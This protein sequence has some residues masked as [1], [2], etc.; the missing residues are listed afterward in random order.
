MIKSEWYEVHVTCAVC[1][2][3]YITG[4]F[5]ACYVIYR[6]K[7]WPTVN[8]EFQHVCIIC[9]QIAMQKVFFCFD[10]VLICSHVRCNMIGYYTILYIGNLEGGVKFTY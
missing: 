10:W 7:F 9:P 1:S 2:S 4:F 3:T 8:K 6:E 5:S